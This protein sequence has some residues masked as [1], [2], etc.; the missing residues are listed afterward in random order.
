MKNWHKILK[1]TLL[2]AFKSSK[3]LASTIIVGLVILVG[4]AVSNIFI[5]GY[6]D[7]EESYSYIEKV[8]VINETGLS[9][10]NENFI[11][12]HQNDYP[13]LSIS[14]ASGVTAKEAASDANLFGENAA[15][16]LVLEVKEEEESCNLTVYIPGFSNIGSGEGAEFA[17]EYSQEVKNSKIKSTGVSEDKV[18]MA[19]SDIR[20]NQVKAEESEEIDEMYD[21]LSSMVQLGVVM[22]LYF[23]IIFYGQSIGQI[24]SMEKTSKLME[25]MLTLT[26]PA[27]IIFGK[28]I[29]V[30]CEAVTQMVVWTACGIAGVK[31]GDI[32]VY[33]FTGGHGKNIVATFMEMLPEGAFSHNFAFLLALTIIAALASFLFYCFV[34]ALFASFAAT[35]EDLSQTT[36][37]AMMTIVIGFLL[38]L[39]IPLFTDNAEWG[40]ALVRII[41]F[42]AAFVLPGDVFSARTS[43]P[44]FILYFSLLLVFTVLLGILTGRVYKNRLFKRG[45]KG[46]FAEI[47][48]AIT[49]KES[50][51]AAE[52][53]KETAKE[54][55]S[56]DFEKYDRAKRTYTIVGFSLLAFILGANAIGGL[57]GGVISNMMAAA[58]GKDLLSVYEDKNFLV[59]NNIIGMYLI[60]VP[61]CAL[62]MKLTNNTVST[63]KGTISKSLYI[64]LILIMFPVTYALAIFSNFLADA[65]S[66]GEAENPLINN[67]LSDSNILAVIM[68]AVLAP[69]FEELVF[70]KLI[71]DRTRR[72]GELTAI[73]YSSLAFGLFHCNI[74]Q[75]FYAF[76]IGLLLGYVY[77]RTGN[78]ILTIIMHMLVNSSS[79]ILY[80]LSPTAYSYFQI[81]VSVLGIVALG[82]TLIKKDIKLEPAKDEVPTKMLSAVAF[83]NVGSLLFTLVCV[84]FMMYQLFVA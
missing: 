55:P 31:I 70:R 52:E 36:G 56:I 19:I 40:L 59:I 78:I 27:G 8:L 81:G 47:L 20:T 73:I 26:G 42:S 62:F 28:V 50:A 69:I 58:T 15:S 48:T 68:V 54:V 25:Y 10:D 63:V 46:I 29:A 11:G 83:R 12:K 4:A 16:S 23:L 6:S 30:F 38:S 53:T 24:V 21:F 65:L 43:M 22:L 67:F 39:Y 14:E 82:Y 34:S 3:F 66:G 37:L 64:R 9:I 71:I 57:V 49:G 35:A 44:E 80:P 75:I 13:F 1:F 41:P 33:R 76:V 74:Y 45:T 60:A 77:I 2:Q 18:K 51:S 32:F 17:R 84:M 79:S 5:S 72:F 61:L 7:D